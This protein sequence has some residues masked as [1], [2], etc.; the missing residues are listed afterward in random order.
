MSAPQTIGR[1]AG[2]TPA[3]RILHLPLSF[4]LTHG[5]ELRGA[6][7][8]YEVLGPDDAPV[9]FVL[10]GISSHRHL[11]AHAADPAPG[12]FE[13]QVGHGKALDTTRWRVVGVD[14]LGG[15][16]DSTGPLDSD[17]SEF[18]A[19]TSHDQARALHCL[20][21]HLGV[22]RA[23]C[24]VGASYGGMV[25]LAFGALAPQR[26]R[27]L[28]VLSAA[29]RPDP[30]ALAWRTVQRRILALGASA[31]DPAAGVA[32]ARALAMTTY[33]CRDELAQRFAVDPAAIEGYLDARGYAFAQ[34]F[35][36]RAYAVLS[37][38]IDLHVVEPTA[39]CVATTLLGV[40]GDQ[41][42][43]IQQVRQLAAR[44]RAPV[45][46]VE[47]DSRYGHDAF[48]KED[49]AIGE[50]LRAALE[51]AAHGGEEVAA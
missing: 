38:A 19:V 26:A 4:P 17:A 18:P 2:L 37:R 10:G 35:D 39:V 23:A 51:A 1:A 22:A 34:R 13:A 5:G 47:I 33:R 27:H 41:L 3:T 28:A 46:L 45:R 8:A 44:L 16:G 30:V 32:L 20:L 40:R 36:P 6:Q 43:P 21:D 29:H 12:W 15:Q 31:G 9:V 24:V 48:L 50:V 7:L 49:Q 42:V 14:F 25:A 11:A